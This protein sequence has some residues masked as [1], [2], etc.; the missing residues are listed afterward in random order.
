MSAGI[1]FADPARD[2]AGILAVYAP[3]IRETAVTFET[4]VPA[5]DAFTARVAGICADFPYLVLEVDGE[6]AGYAYAHRQA[7]RAAYAWNAELSI[8][9]A[10]KWRG[11]G[12]GAPLYRLLERLLTMQGYVNLYGVITAS[13][14]G[15]IRLHEKLGYRQ[16]GLHEKTGWKFGQWHDVAW[17]HKRVREG[18]PGTIL[19]LS[20]L[21]PAQ[22]E[23]EIAAAQREIEE[24]LKM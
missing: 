21:D 9:L 15:S 5:P 7:E 19:P 10:G 1:R 8:Y 24:K 12:L 3:Y 2:A 20:A 13:N 23:R 16:T 18:E 11:R 14:A 6:L 22:V 4:E 17:L